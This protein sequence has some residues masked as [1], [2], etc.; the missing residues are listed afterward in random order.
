MNKKYKAYL[1]VRRIDNNEIVHKVGVSA[2]GEDYIERVMRGMLRNMNIDDF[3]ID[4][5]EADKVRE[6]E[7]K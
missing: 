2:V 5:S 3:Y 4:D 6:E 7:R 1:Y